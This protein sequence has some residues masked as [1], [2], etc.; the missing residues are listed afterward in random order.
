M[1]LAQVPVGVMILAKTRE[2][3]VSE[4]VI[5]VLIRADASPVDGMGW[6]DPWQEVWFEDEDIEDWRLLNGLD[7]VKP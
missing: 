2:T 5:T 1:R 3:P 7:T 6:I 4:P